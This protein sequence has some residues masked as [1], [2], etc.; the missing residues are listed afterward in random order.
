[1]LLRASSEQAI[2][3]GHLIPH[4]V[5]GSTKPEPKQQAGSKKRG[6][7]GD[8]GGASAKKAKVAS[9]ASAASTSAGGSGTTPRDPN[10]DGYA[11]LVP[12]SR[13]FNVTQG[14]DAFEHKLLAGLDAD[15]AAVFKADITI[16]RGQYSV[17]LRSVARAFGFTLEREAAGANGAKPA[18]IQR[19][20]VL[21]PLDGFLPTQFVA[22]LTKVPAPGA[23]A[24]AGIVAPAPGPLRES[25]IFDT[26]SKIDT[27][28]TFRHELRR[29][30]LWHRLTPTMR[31]VIK[32]LA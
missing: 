10:M 4:E 3:G 17:P 16:A 6:P 22:N 26:S 19:D 20:D 25:T 14:W 7:D 5:W 15:E 1:M 28:K 30:S 9:A 24:P 11:N 18:K 8:L 29:T 31:A 12:M 13:T 2:E 27:A 23:A 32:G 21:G